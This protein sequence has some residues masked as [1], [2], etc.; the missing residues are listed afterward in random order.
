VYKNIKGY[1]KIMD[2]NDSRLKGTVIDK[3]LIDYSKWDKDK[4]FDSISDYMFHNVPKSHE[5]DGHLIAMLTETMATYIQCVIAIKSEGLVIYNQHGNI[6]GKSPCV[7]VMHTQ[8]AL[9]VKIM[10]ELKLL[11][12]DRLKKLS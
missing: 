9:I 6:I 5:T 2:K 7:K 11:P 1:K 3:W 8:L 12:K 10:R 4:F